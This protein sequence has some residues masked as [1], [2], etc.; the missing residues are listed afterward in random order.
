MN[1]APGQ[2]GNQL[3]LEGSRNYTKQLETVKRR[4][5]N[6]NVNAME[7]WKVDRLSVT[8][9]LELGGSLGYMETDRR[10]RQSIVGAKVDDQNWMRYIRGYGKFED[11]F[12]RLVRIASATRQVELQDKGF[13]QPCHSHH[14]RAASD[15]VTMNDG[16]LVK[17]E[18]QRPS[19]LL[20]QPEIPEWQWDLGCSIYHWSPVLWAEIG[21]SSLIGPE[22]VQ[23]TTDKVVLIKEKLR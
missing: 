9:K 14:G 18:H 23:E 13:I 16:S 17:A 12:R 5:L 20:Q 21:E 4:L 6:V 15:I 7:A 8:A 1:R 3:A 10:N 2:A 19:G 11:G 22:L